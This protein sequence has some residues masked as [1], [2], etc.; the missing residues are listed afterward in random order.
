MLR[1]RE[2]C[3]PPLTPVR[4]LLPQPPLKGDRMKLS[5]SLCT[6]E[7]VFTEGVAQLGS[8][9]PATMAW[10]EE[11]LTASSLALKFPVLAAI[12]SLS[13]FSMNLPTQE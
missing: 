3:L 11:V 4:L 8:C 1:S 5:A 10:Q 12:V 13:L 9:G 7:Q 2:Q 6:H